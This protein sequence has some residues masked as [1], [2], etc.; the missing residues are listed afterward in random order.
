MDH[1][2]SFT[3]D[4]HNGIY[5]CDPLTKSRYSSSH[6]EL[7]IL[8]SPNIT[9]DMVD[10]NISNWICKVSCRRIL[11]PR[12]NFPSYV[13]RFISSSPL[14]KWDCKNAR[15]CSNKSIWYIKLICFS[16]T[17]QISRSERLNCTR[18]THVMTYVQLRYVEK[19]S[20]LHNNI[21]T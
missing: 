18:V 3:S 9:H 10:N 6:E 13:T 16:K 15:L 8:I 11:W 2:I 19:E 14:I 1:Y 20:R 21:F 7:Y 17:T 5:V 4:S 12:W